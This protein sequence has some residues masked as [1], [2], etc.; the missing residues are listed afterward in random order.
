MENIEKWQL[1]LV[2][3]TNIPTS[4]TSTFW[5]ITTGIRKLAN[6]PVTGFTF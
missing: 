3:T 1:T 4:S 5:T 2:N 6:S